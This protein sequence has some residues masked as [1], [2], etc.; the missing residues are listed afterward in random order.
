MIKHFELLR[1]I[2]YRLFL[3][4]A[5]LFVFNSLSAQTITGERRVYYLDATYSMVSNKLWEPSKEN[6]IK[7]IENIEDVN[8]EIVVVVFSDDINPSKRVWEKWEENATSS[9]KDILINNIK[10]LANPVTT[11]M[12]NLYDPWMDFYSEIKQG[13]VNYMFLMTDGGH[14]QGGDFLA[15]IDQWKQ[16]TNSLT[17]GFFVELTEN[18]GPGEINAR[19]MARQ[20]IDRQKERLWRVSTADVNIN[21]IRLEQSATFNVRGDK[22]IDV[23]IYFSGKDRATIKE[24]NFEFVNNTDFKVQKIDISDNGARIYIDSSVDIYSYPS[25]NNVPLAIT[26]KGTDDKTFLLTETINIKCLNK[27]EK[28]MFLSDSRITGKVEHYDSFAWVESKTTPY[29]TEINLDFSQDALN[30]PTAFVDLAVVDNNGDILSPSKVLFSLDGVP[31]A[32]NIIKI[33]PNDKSITL[34]ISFP[35]GSKTGIHQGY[36][37]PLNYNMDR[38][39]NMELNNSTSDYPVIWRVR[40][41]HL[42]NPLAKLVMWFCIFIISAALFWFLILKPLK[43]PRFPKFRK[44]VLVKKDRAVVAQFTVNFKGARCVVFA[45]KKQRQSTLNK[46]FTGKIDTIVNPVFED[47]ITF[48]PKRKKKAMAKG[49]GYLFNPNPIPQSGAAEISSPSKK[50]II[51]LK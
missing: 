15:A 43:Y 4:A 17:Y 44:M 42:M 21:L 51:T 40:Y 14:E 13:K 41:T 18:V 2:I 30:D 33:K 20:H 37:K 50:I 46:L 12:T 8:T 26:L 19:N 28:V 16:S 6:L 36:L 24:L 34:S 23:P 1:Y 3:F 5:C 9:G 11:T 39:G 35:D 22:F 49:N 10:G 32:D 48:I 31:C 45:N 29:Y 27:K 47:P 38:I 25:S 7:A